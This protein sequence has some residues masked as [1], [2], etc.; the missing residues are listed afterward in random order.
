MLGKGFGGQVAFEAKWSV[1]AP[2][3]LLA[4][5][6]HEFRSRKN[7]RFSM[8]CLALFETGPEVP[9]LED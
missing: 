5:L 8:T 2:R 3:Y 6:K 9:E 1:L 4:P 7:A